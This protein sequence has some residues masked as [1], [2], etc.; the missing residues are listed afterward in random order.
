M[1]LFLHS[2]FA[3]SGFCPKVT[4]WVPRLYGLQNEWYGLVAS[5]D[6]YFNSVQQEALAEQLRELKR[7]YE[8][9]GREI[10]FFFVSEPA[11]LEKFPSDAKR[12]ARPCVA[13]VST[14]KA[15]IT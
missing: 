11:W 10:D 6:F 5:A 2:H 1:Q 14:D 7:Y 9:K 8:E 15:W 3:A 4:L 13:L 12:V